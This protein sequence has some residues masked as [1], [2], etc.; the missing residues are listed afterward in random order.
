MALPSAGSSSPAPNHSHRLTPVS[1]EGKAPIVALIGNPNS[2]KSSLF[3]LLTGFRRHVANYPGVSVDVGRA[4]VRG[5]ARRVELLDLPGS[6]SL[7][8]LSPDE[9]LVR[10]AL[11]G[12]LAHTPKPDAI[13]V[14]VDATNLR[15]NL[16]LLTE[17]YEFHLP[18]VVA[19]NMS[20]IARARGLSIDDRLLGERLGAAVVPA[21]A[22]RSAS[23]GPL[24]AAIEQAIDHAAPTEPPSS[25]P[26]R[27]ASP[28][29]RYDWIDGALDGVVKRVGHSLSTHS[30]RADRI[31]THPLWGCLI[32][33][34]VMFVIFQSI[35]T[36][37]APLMD[38]IDGGFGWLSQAA[39]GLAPAGAWRSFVTDGLIGGVGGVLIFLPQILILFAFIALLE[40]LGYMARAAFMMDRA[41]RVFGLTGRAFIPLLSSYACAV[42]AIMGTRA[43]SDRRE[44]FVTILIAPFMSCSARLPV[45]VLITAALIPATPFLGGWIDLRGL[46]LLAMYIVGLVVAAPIAWLLRRTAFRGPPPSFMLELPSYKWPRPRAIWA[47]MWAAGRGFVVRAG[48]IILAVN[49]M[50]WALAYFP[51]SPETRARVEAT[52]TAESWDAERFDH[53]LA[54]AYQRDSY[55]GRMGRTIEP[56]VRPIGWDWRIGMAV[57]ASFPAREVVVSTLGTIYNLG[58]NENEASAPLQQALKDARWPGGRP[59]FTIPVGLSIMVF[60]ALCAQCSSTLVVIGRETQSWLWPIVSFVAMTAM[61]WMAAWMTSTLGGVVTAAIR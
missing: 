44:R 52:A 3:N 61:A 56:L 27:N 43:I 50:V 45:Y 57:I 9:A 12:R 35:F 49:L 40:D 51:H 41:M 22:T 15:R 53:E 60:F 17:L 16:F 29:Q 48:T 8:A 59:V 21:V 42:P 32:L 4:P 26:A 10:D 18:I 54:G 46:V 23:A 11:E 28:E 2:G 58:A 36:W 14:V 7:T 19:L 25:P 39:G 55:L 38:F 13:V 1:I 33:L 31:V 37:A 24:R 30:E 20:D 6:Y 34:A 47:R 5:I